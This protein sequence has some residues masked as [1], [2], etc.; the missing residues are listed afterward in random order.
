[1]NIS[2]NSASR[3]TR[4]RRTSDVGFA[5][6]PICK[7]VGSAHPTLLIAKRIGNIPVCKEKL[8]QLVEGD[9]AAITRGRND[10]TIQAAWTSADAQVKT[11]TGWLTRVYVGV[12]GVTQLPN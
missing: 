2:I 3:Q 1:M 10:G 9:A 8:R 12:D 4:T 7:K 6:P 5:R 11:D